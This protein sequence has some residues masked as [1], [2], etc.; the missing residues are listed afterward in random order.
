MRH[1]R[2]QPSLARGLSLLWFPVFFA[3]VLGALALASFTQ[4]APHEM[5]VGVVAS[6]ADADALAGRLDA[7]YP[8]GFVTTTYASVLD[9][10]DAIVHQDVVA[11]VVDRAPDAE[12]LVASGS[13]NTR[14]TYLAKV[15]PPILAAQGWP[16][17]PTVTDVVPR[18]SDDATGNAMMFWAMPLMVTGFVT[19]ILLLQLAAWSLVRKSTVIAIIGAL[20]SLSLYVTAALLDV[21]PSEPLLLVYGF[22]LTQAVAWL[23]TG[24]APFVKQ[25]FLPVT[26]TFVLVLG[27]PSATGTMPT[28]LLPAI[29]RWLS[30]VMPLSQAIRLGRATAYFHDHGSLTP[31]LILFGWAVL[32]AALMVFGERRT[33]HH[34]RLAVLAQ[35]EAASTPAPLDGPD[36]GGQAGIAGTIRTLGG[37]PV[38]GATVTVLSPGGRIWSGT[39]D[40]D[41]A[42]VISGLPVGVVHVAVTAPHAEPELSTVVIHQRHPR[43]RHHVVLADWEAPV[44]EAAESAATATVD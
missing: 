12:L 18:R 8:E 32:G 23:T 19:S 1:A 42:Y 7:L 16:G 15:L 39:T 44:F 20:A 9:A 33:A 25:F 10:R 28:D 13:S 14:A 43:V 37:L 17:T 36:Q 11:A 3:A 40:P 41:G 26:A 31:L 5:R 22:L 21:L 29:P 27:L 2:P 34:H 24:S 30:E 4:P 38:T 35:Q 6:P